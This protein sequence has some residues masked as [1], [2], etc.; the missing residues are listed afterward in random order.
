V[1]IFLP[2][3]VYFVRTL[4]VIP[5]EEGMISA[6]STS[7]GWLLTGPSVSVAEAESILSV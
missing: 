4:V 6:C 7:C 2:V 5:I 3:G 1:F